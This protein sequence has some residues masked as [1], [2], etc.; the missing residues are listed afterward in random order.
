MLAALTAVWFALMAF[1]LGRGALWWIGGAILALCVSAICLGLTH[2]VAL[3]YAPSELRRM[4]SI[5]IVSAVLL[6][7]ATGAIIGV[8]NARAHQ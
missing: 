3:P 7:A 1:K 4:E 2:A 6:I 8:G 5:G